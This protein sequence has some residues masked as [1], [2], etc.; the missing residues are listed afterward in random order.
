[1]KITVVTYLDS[2][3][4]NSREYD[5]VVPQIARTLRR[6]GHRV[7]VLGVHGDVKRLIAGLARRKPEL[8]F[9]LVEMFADDVFGD[10]AVT[11]LLDLLGLRY[12]GCGP[13]ELYL[14]QD[15]SLSKK[16]LA[17][18]HIP[19]PKF[20]VFSKDS[21]LE[22]G[23]NLRMPLF[24]KPLRS[25]SSIGIGRKSIV[26]DA[27]QLM[28]RVAAIHEDY[29]DSAI[30]EEFIEGRE[31]LVGVLGNG[32]AKALPP[33]EVDFSGL[34]EGSP[35]VLDSKAKWEEGSAEYKGTK[36]VVAALPD[37]LRARLQKVAV[38]AYRAVRVRDYG[39]VDLR[40]TDTGEIYVLEVNASCYLE[41]ESEF[42]MAAKAA[43][44]DYPRLIER[45]VSLAVER[46]GGGN[47][48]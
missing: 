26:H 33:I 16:L 11:G 7:S 31:F 39:R 30:A 37:E 41:R 23:G 25:D 46:T 21:A 35:K 29:N 17:Y 43:G 42:A 36:T 40:L 18:E 48:R 3:D 6:L 12:T 19:Y 5:P 24:V 38:D 9:N 22:T 47:G 2:P 1:M 10:I 45:I 34:P 28:R 8:V 15:K 20:A 32:P 13:G 14:S 4:E 44:L 27:V